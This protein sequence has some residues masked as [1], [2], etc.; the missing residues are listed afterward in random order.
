[1]FF[2]PFFVLIVY[3]QTANTWRIKS[4][5]PLYSGEGPGDEDISDQTMLKR[6]EK[7]EKDEKQRKR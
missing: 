1:M 2:F 7:F 5:N 6:H 3:F 4:T